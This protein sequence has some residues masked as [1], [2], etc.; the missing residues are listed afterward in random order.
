MTERGILRI[1]QI[2]V[3]IAVIV[4]LIT[5]AIWGTWVVSE[6]RQRID[7]Q[8]SAVDAKIEKQVV[9]SHNLVKSIEAL[10]ETIGNKTSDHYTA[11]D[12]YVACLEEEIENP[13]WVCPQ[14]AQR[15][16]ALA[17]SSWKTRVRAN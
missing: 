4:S 1:G 3:P 2:Y 14:R 8:I 12:A 10:R 15:P 17:S 6:E 5:F 9:V 16:K 13:G 11:R 7:D